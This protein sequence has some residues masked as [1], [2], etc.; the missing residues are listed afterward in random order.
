VTA[1][2]TANSA[3]APG[4]N[5]GTAPP[6]APRAIAPN[7]SE[8]AG[9]QT[10]RPREKPSSVAAMTPPHARTG[11][12]ARGCAR[13]ARASAGGGAE[14]RGRVAERAAVGQLRHGAAGATIHAVAVET[15]LV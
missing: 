15:G 7:Q 3:A 5:A 14:G 13:A 1:L 12:R 11:T 9:S 8:R 2:V 4:V 6:R 10:T